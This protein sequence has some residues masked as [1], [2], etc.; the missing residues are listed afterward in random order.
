MGDIGGRSCGHVVE[1]RNLV[2]LGKESVTKVRTYKTGAAGDKNAHGIKSIGAKSA[3]MLGLDSGLSD[4]LATALPEAGVD[5][6]GWFA[7]SEIDDD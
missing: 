5:G 1:D 4:A 7:Q 2:V 3:T 6:S